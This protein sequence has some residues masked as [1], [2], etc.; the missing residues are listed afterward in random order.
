MEQA[1][2]EQAYTQANLGGAP[3]WVRLLEEAWPPEWKRKGF[4]DP[5]CPLDLALYGHPDAG[6]YWE[7]HSQSKMAQEGFIVVPG[8]RSCFWH[9]KLNAFVCIYV[10]D[11][12]V[13]CPK[14]NI[15]QVWDKITR[16]IEVG[17]PE[18]I[19]KFLGCNHVYLEGPKAEIAMA[20]AQRMEDGAFADATMLLQQLSNYDHDHNSTIVGVV[21]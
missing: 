20:A 2:A 7:K 6:G 18:P 8:R 1:D 10:D 9:P 4:R 3:T 19:G 14:A 11:Y 21:W 12:K 17:A 15:K 5:V 16:H 13:A